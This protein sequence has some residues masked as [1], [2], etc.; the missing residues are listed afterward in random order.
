ME[1]VNTKEQVQELLKDYPELQGFSSR[2]QSICDLVKDA[3][4]ETD[5]AFMADSFKTV[6]RLQE[7]LHAEMLSWYSTEHTKQFNGMAD[8]CQGWKENAEK[9]E[10]AL[11]EERQAN[12]E[13]FDNMCFL[14]LVNP[15][16]AMED[17]ILKNVERKKKIEDSDGFNNWQWGLHFPLIARLRMAW[18]LIFGGREVNVN[19]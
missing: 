18:R 11:K 1:D 4:Q 10:A 19:A 15:R 2:M 7:R 3:E 17:I 9:L 6:L 13:V 16:A 14:M 8:N 12:N 5:P